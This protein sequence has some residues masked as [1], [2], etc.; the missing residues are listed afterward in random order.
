MFP[1]RHRIW[2][3]LIKQISWLVNIL[4]IQF[5]LFNMDRHALVSVTNYLQQVN[6]VP[7]IIDI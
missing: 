1:D 5:Y 7:E 4:L 2:H 6:K 3:P